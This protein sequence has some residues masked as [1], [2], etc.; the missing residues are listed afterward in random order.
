MKKRCFHFL[1]ILAV[2]LF[3]PCIIRAEDSAIL[4]RQVGKLSYADGKP[5]FEFF[6]ELNG[7]RYD[8]VDTLKSGIL[9]L[10]RGTVIVFRPGCRR[11]GGEPLDSPLEYKELGTYCELHG[12]IFRVARSSDSPIFPEKEK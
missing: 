11:F 5:I 2:T 8:S 10:E 1:F 6:F 9:S 7:K 3:T 4:Q 12:I